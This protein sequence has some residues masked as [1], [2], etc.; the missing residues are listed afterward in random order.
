MAVRERRTAVERSDERADERPD[1]RS[2]GRMCGQ[3]LLVLVAVAVPA[4]SL[5]HLPHFSPWPVLAGLVPWMVGKYVLCPLRWHALSDSGRNRRW[6]LRIFAEAE[7]LG[8][9]TPGH[10]GSDVWRIRRLGQVGVRRADAV[11]EV[12]LDRFIG[13]IGLTAFVAVAGMALP[14]R[15]LLGALATG[16]VAIVAGLVVRRRRPDLVPTRALPSRR[17]V[18]HGVALSLGY[19][20]SVCALL[21]GTVAATG[22]SVSALGLVGAFGASQL[23]GAIPGPNGASP[24]DG[25]LVVGLVGLGVPWEA[26]VGA[27]ALKA[28]LAWAPALLLGGGALLLLRRAA[29][30]AAHHSLHRCAAHSSAA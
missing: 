10:V 11:T 19:Q 17:Q 29:R 3:A 21:L 9:L 30:A 16:L 24:R 28:T 8:L 2:Y 20:V 14:L 15:M 1:A 26:A 25:A 6:H 5:L 22:N 18:L 12:G 13:A 4:W 23:A 7:L 27:V